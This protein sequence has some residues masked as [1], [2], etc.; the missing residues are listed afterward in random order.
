MQRVN[1]FCWSIMSSENPLC[2]ARELE[3]AH[4]SR[5][6]YDPIDCVELGYVL[7]A[8]ALP[9][10]YA[11]DVVPIH[12]VRKNTTY[13]FSCVSRMQPDGNAHMIVEC[14]LVCDYIRV[15]FIRPDNT[16]E[17]MIL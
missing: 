16:K 10:M 2:T 12:G 3:C 9:Q 14:N 7:D 4:R 1:M 8:F 5:I 15:T 13:A 11:L 6:V 17:P